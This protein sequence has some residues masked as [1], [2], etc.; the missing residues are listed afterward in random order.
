MAAPDHYRTLELDPDASHE[1][2]KQAYRRLAKR[3]HPDTSETGGDR[4]QIVRVNAAYA[5]LGD[6]QA[7]HAYDAQ[8]GEQTTHPSSV[9]RQERS[10]RAQE[11]YGRQR[12][13]RRDANSQLHRWLREVYAPVLHDVRQ[14]LRPLERELERLSA[15]PF[16]DDL[17]DAFADYLDGCR[18]R[19][20]SARTTLTSCPN[21]PDAASTAAR[22]YYCLDRL[23]DGIDE[24]AWF[25]YNFNEQYLHS[26]IEL[27]RIARSLRDEAEASAQVAR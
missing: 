15:D 8:F 3:Y 9:R 1:Q 7:R 25:P 6:P 24:L 4:E 17:L 12:Q 16:D 18:D 14:I 11:Q 20:D 23:G 19:L 21:P 27:F 2:I 22:L 26:G 10:A 13:A 5:V